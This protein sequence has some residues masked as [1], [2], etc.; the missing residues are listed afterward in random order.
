[1]QR[2]QFIRT[3]AGVVVAAASPIVARAQTPETPERQIALVEHGTGGRLGVAAIDT[4]HGR[5][6]EYRAFEAFPMCSTFKLLLV[7]D[8][9]ARVDAGKERWI[10]RFP[11]AITICSTT[12]R[13]PRPTSRTAG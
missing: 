2:P 10:A 8:I 6:I 9:L 3:V 5:R 12:R 4:G 13:S 7:G 11:T 1:M